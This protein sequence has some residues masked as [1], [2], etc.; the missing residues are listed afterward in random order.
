[1]I[2]KVMSDYPAVRFE[3]GLSTTQWLKRQ[4]VILNPAEWGGDLEV[5]LLAIGLKRDIVVLTDASNGATY[6]RRFPYQPPPIPKMAGGIFIPISTKELCKHWK[7]CNPQPLL[8]IYNG[9]SH[10]DS[11]VHLVG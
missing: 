11:V 1:M 4:Q 9:H 8:T 2:V 10:Y 6:A 3:D 5:R 7:S